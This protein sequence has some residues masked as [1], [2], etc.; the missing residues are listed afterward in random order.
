[1]ESNF[2]VKIKFTKGSTV[3]NKT[4]KLSN[5]PTVKHTIFCFKL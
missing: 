1:M 4:A 2:E 3:T 5:D